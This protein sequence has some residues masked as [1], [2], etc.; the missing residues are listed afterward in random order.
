MP[1][2]SLTNQSLF[3]NNGRRR[4]K[5]NM[6]LPTVMNKLIDEYGTPTIDNDYGRDFARK[7][8]KPL[9]NL[10]FPYFKLLPTH[11]KSRSKFRIIHTDLSLYEDCNTVFD[12]LYG[13]R[14]CRQTERTG[15]NKAEQDT[16][17]SSSGSSQR[18]FK[19][20]LGSRILPVDKLRGMKEVD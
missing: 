10:T 19:K 12:E 16:E 14:A 15:I 17:M 13:K 6:K 11:P 3:E 9:I 7:P 5:R 4:S 8:F 18:Y 20:K 2:S 1:R